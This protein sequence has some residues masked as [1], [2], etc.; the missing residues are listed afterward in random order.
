MAD[1][2]EYRNIQEDDY[3][4]LVDWWKWH[5]FPAPPR[6]ILPD[7]ISD[8][9]MVS[10]NGE[11]V[12]AG[13]VYRTSSSSLFWCEWIVSSYKI[14]DKEVRKKAISNLIEAIKFLAN[15]MG[16]KVIYTSLINPLLKQAYLDS[17]FVVGSSSADE[18][19][20]RF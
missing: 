8:G 19:I 1:L 17:G 12:C 20:F 3:S 9:I 15:E 13:F 7:N 5:R 2:F 11:N 18:L 10:V 4:I 16:A 6:E 14:R